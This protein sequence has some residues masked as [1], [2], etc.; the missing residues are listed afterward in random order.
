[1]GADILGSH[2]NLTLGTWASD[3]LLAVFFFVVGLE[4]KQEIVAGELHDVSR[5]VLPIAAAVGGMV[6]PA[7]AFVALTAH[8]GEGAV[9]GWAIPIATDIAIAVAVLAVI[10][11]H[12]PA[13]LRTFLLTLAVVDPATM[14]VH[15]I[16]GLRVVDASVM[17][18]IP[19]GNIYAPT[20]MIA[21][22]AA[23]WIQQST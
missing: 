10:S 22:K 8:L 19:N 14:Q 16:D 7:A 5:A 2:L 23:Q 3:G 21:E 11:T 1:M 20:M 12:L 4:L 18:Y 6:V 15:G 13:A 9:N 17:P